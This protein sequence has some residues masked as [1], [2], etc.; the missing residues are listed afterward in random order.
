MKTVVSLNPFE[1]IINVTIRD[2]H[3]SS[4]DLYKIAEIAENAV[5]KN[6]E[7]YLRIKTFAAKLASESEEESK[8]G[9]DNENGA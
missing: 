2:L 7:S 4:D 1:G 9:C 8:E 3:V 5:Q 6:I